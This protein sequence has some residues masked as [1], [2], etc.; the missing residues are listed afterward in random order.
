MTWPKPTSWD[1]FE[2]EALR[3]IVACEEEMHSMLPARMVYCRFLGRIR[4][5]GR[6]TAE[7]TLDPVAV[8]DARVKPH[9]E[10]LVEICG[11]G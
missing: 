11:L 6:E 8:I 4:S 5:L 7:A 10:R 2:R 3:A 9:D 1:E